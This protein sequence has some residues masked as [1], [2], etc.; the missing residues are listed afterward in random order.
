[1]PQ[2]L[3]LREN[4][5]PGQRVRILL[6]GQRFGILTV[7]AYS[8]NDKNGKAVW[9]CICDCGNKTTSTGQNLL[10]GASKSCGC[11]RLKACTRH[12]K[13]K[14]PEYNSYEG[15]K[16]RCTNKK[17]SGYKDYGGRGIQFKFDS[18]EAF[19]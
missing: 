10:N 19:Y 3:K 12:G 1:M 9:E 16:M 17:Y 18:F 6:N 4:P 7:I 8:H 5:Q 14:T 15:A 2:T 11:L 13:A